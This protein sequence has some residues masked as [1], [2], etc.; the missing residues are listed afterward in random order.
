MARNADGIA[1]E[2]YDVGNPT[3]VKNM[4]KVDSTSHAGGA[5]AFGP[6]GK[7]Y[8][9]VGDGTSY[10]YADPRSFYVQDPDSLV[11]KILRIDPI[12]GRG[13]A[14][15]P[16]VDP[17]A[18]LTDNRSKVWQLGL[19][20]PFTMEFDE[21]GQL[22]IS[23]V[24]WAKWEE[25]NTGEAGA[26][27]GWPFY[28]GGDNGVL[29]LNPN[30]NI[31]PRVLDGTFTA[32]S[33][34]EITAA[35]RAFS[36][37]RADPGFQM[38]AIVGAGFISGN[39]VYP[40]ALDGHY[41]FADLESGRIFAIDP[42]D[43]RDV[44]F[45]IERDGTGFAPVRYE[46]GPDGHIYYADV[47]GGHF[48]RIEIEQPALPT[49]QLSAPADVPEGAAG[50]TGAL[51]F[52]VTLSQPA[53]PGGVTAN[54]SVTGGGAV[55]PASLA[56]AQGQTTATISVQVVG[57]NTVEPDE[58]VTV[59]LSNLQ[60]ATG[61]GLSAS[62][63]ILNDDLP[64]SQPLQ[65]LGSATYAPA[66][67]E[68]VLTT[69]AKN[70]IGGAATPYRIDLRQDAEISFE[71]F[72]GTSDSGADGL[73]LALHADPRGARC[74][75]PA[76]PSSASAASPTASPSVSTP[77]RAP[78]SRPRTMPRSTTPTAPSPARGCRWPTSRT[79]SGGRSS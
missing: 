57:D 26:N 9:S 20:N 17:G 34:S 36:H 19:R 44:M 23:D 24:G 3:F 45:L 28:E 67:D 43:R 12:N 39:D 13:L 70:Q 46:Q 47:A 18:D 75:A 15:N 5:L 29:S 7:L 66:T 8:V 73:A 41:V 21:S 48:G 52:T 79:A 62:A 53:G 76:A 31:D 60:N 40:A 49:L 25:I 71:M 37:T 16:F 30:Y 11:G 55:T 56:I 72:L 59:T 6:D 1:T 64:P 27:F 61:T 42:D 78:A 35:L 2:P 77:T 33:P 65:T 68:F 38:T 58:T 54:I 14:D 74:S 10:N 63:E 50:Q 22:F 69:A 51:V 4:L 32:P